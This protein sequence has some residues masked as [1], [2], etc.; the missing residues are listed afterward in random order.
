MKVSPLV[1]LLGGALVGALALSVPLPTASH[2]AAAEPTTLSLRQSEVLATEWMP[3]LAV[4]YGPSLGP[5]LSQAN[6]ILYTTPTVFFMGHWFKMGRTHTEAVPAKVVQFEPL[7]NWCDGLGIGKDV[8]GYLGVVYN[9]PTV[10]I[11]VASPQARPDPAT[12][13]INGNVSHEPS[14]WRNSDS[15]TPRQPSQSTPL[16]SV[17]L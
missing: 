3:I 13:S 10:G 12:V 9:E 4:G 5:F 17:H 6:G 16:L 11:V 7:G 15:T 8:G 2:A 14:D 1:L